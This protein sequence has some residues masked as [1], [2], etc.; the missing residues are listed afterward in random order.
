M[1]NLQDRLS[2]LMQTIA[3]E[4]LTPIVEYVLEHSDDFTEGAD[5][6]ALVQQLA[7]ELQIEQVEAKSAG[8]RTSSSA[9]A[10]KTKGLSAGK[11]SSKTTKSN[12]KG[13]SGKQWLSQKEFEKAVGDSDEDRIEANICSYSPPRGKDKGLF[14]GAEADYL[15]GED[16][17]DY[18]EFRCESC[19]TKIGRGA[20]LLN[21]EDTG[22]TKRTSSKKAISGVSSRSKKTT[23]KN[24][25][26][27]AGSKK[28]PSDEDDDED[29]EDDDETP[30]IQ[31]NP[32]DSLTELLGE[33]AYFCFNEGIE[34][35]VFMSDGDEYILFGHYKGKTVLNDET[36]VTPKLLGEFVSYSAKDKDAQAAAKLLSMTV[37][38]VEE[39]MKIVNK[40]E[41]EQ[42]KKKKTP[43]KK[44]VKGD[45]NND[46]E[47]QPKKKKTPPKKPAKN[48]DDDDEEEKPKK[49]VKK[50]A[51][52]D[53]DDDEEEKP[54]K[55]VKK[56]AKNDD[57]DD[58]EKKPKK[59]V[60]KPVKNDD[61]DEEE[62]PKKVVKNP[63]PTKKPSKTPVKQ[64]DEE[65]QPK[66][67]KTK[68]V[69]KKPVKVDD[70]EEE[71]PKEEKT[72]KVVKKPAK[73]D[74]DEEEEQPKSSAASSKSNP[75]TSISSTNSKEEEKKVED[76]DEDNEMY[77]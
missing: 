64:D 62:K 31:A 25:K 39:M 44:V 28:K 30:T 67:E 36:E 69:V 24:T 42:P 32:N 50:P 8:K 56:P 52:N 57:D 61:D 22:S 26:S 33:G 53:D 66:E 46:E 54:K 37:S 4:L 16:G 72:K 5:V 2:G 41:E 75:K 15:G 1:S 18:T 6:E 58:E 68:K 59:V 40:D 9:I 48:D 3:S 63:T 45:D 14:C 10:A 47:E 35:S 12:K 7:D 70:D 55:V 29:E 13:D 17:V 60:K 23:S 74:D 76:D 19:K 27:K 71:Q 65:E 21:G 49:V 73:N 20:K 38:T 77:D 11:A 43:P 34:N 51:K